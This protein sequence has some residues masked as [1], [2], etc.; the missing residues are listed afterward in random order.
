MARGMS[1]M[2]DDP[3]LRAIPRNLRSFGGQAANEAEQIQWYLL[4][5]VRW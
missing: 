2:L 4:G 5:D 3:D 1:L